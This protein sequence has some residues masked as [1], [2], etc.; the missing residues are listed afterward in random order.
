LVLPS[1]GGALPTR[2]RAHE[3]LMP[4]PVQTVHAAEREPVHVWSYIK[5]TTPAACATTKRPSTQARSQQIVRMNIIGLELLLPHRTREHRSPSAANMSQSETISVW[6]QMTCAGRQAARLVSISI[7]T[8]GRAI[9]KR[10]DHDPQ[11]G[12]AASWSG[13]MMAS[14]ARADGGSRR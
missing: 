14:L 8:A 7:W 10:R 11:K 3:N 9:P 5:G 6:H 4:S 2:M 1:P 12:A 13:G